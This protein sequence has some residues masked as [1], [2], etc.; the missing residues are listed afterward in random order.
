[1]NAQ[2]PSGGTA[3]LTAVWYNRLAVVRILLDN[4]ADIALCGDF[5]NW[6]ALNVAYFSGYTELV[7]LIYERVSAEKPLSFADVVFASRS[8]GSQSKLGHVIPSLEIDQ[9]LRNGETALIISCDQGDIKTVERLLEKPNNDINVA[10]PEGWTPLMSASEWGHIDVVLLLLAKGAFVNE[11]DEE[12][13]TALQIACEYDH[14]DVVKAL[15]NYGA[16]VDSAAEDGHTPL[17][18]AAT[19]GNNDV[20]KLLLSKGASI[21][22]PGPDG[23][24]LSQSEAMSGALML[25]KSS[26]LLDKGASVDMGTATPLMTAIEQGHTDIAAMLLEK[27]AS[28]DQQCSDG[29]TALGLARKRGLLDFVKL[30]VEN[31][32]SL[33]LTDS[34]GRTP[35]QMADSE[36]HTAVVKYLETRQGA[37]AHDEQSGS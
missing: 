34:S 36:G 5:Q 30:L 32:A 35:L 13:Y 9:K 2:L 7:Q 27:H 20:V 33:E 11:A 6:S 4:G 1:M 21:D 26:Y 18:L 16:S 25:L 10:N 31:G 3:L 37:D 29:T 23:A 15:I 17:T 28:V 24:L 12:G 22:K 8:V 19:K 14:L